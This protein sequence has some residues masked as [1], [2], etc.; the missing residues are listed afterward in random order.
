MTTTETV[1]AVATASTAVVLV[2]QWI[3]SA[4]RRKKRDTRRRNQ[5]IREL[6]AAEERH[7]VRMAAIDQDGRDRRLQIVNEAAGRGAYYSSGRVDAEARVQHE[8][9]E[10]REEE[11]RRYELERGELEDELRDLGG[12]VPTDPA[13]GSGPRS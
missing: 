6:P 11:R 3:S 2:A 1:T 10:A 13:D 9:E 4:R 12:A 5:I 8:T 7:R